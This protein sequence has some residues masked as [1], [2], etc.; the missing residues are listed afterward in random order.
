MSFQWSPQLVKIFVDCVLSEVRKGNTAEGGFK[1]QQWTCIVEAFNNHA[2]VAADKPVLQNK[3]MQMKKK[4]VI[5]K[6]L[7]SNS[8]FGWDDALQIPTAP[9][10]VWNSYLAVHKEAR[11]FQRKTFEYFDEFDEIYSDHIATGSHALSTQP[12]GVQMSRMS[13]ESVHVHAQEEEIER[14]AYSS[15]SSRNNSIH[16]T[17]TQIYDR[18]SSSLSSPP[19]SNLHSTGAIQVEKTTDALH[20]NVQV[21]SSSSSTFSRKRGRKGDIAEAILQAMKDR[22]A[23]PTMTANS[24]FGSI[25]ESRYVSAVQGANAI[26]KVWIKPRIVHNMG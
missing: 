2:G 13:A 11:E 23:P 14:N 16:S 19:I 4:F 3:L 10:S 9:E 18:A 17:P 7:K 21:L 1:K 8:G 22:R 12:Y 5:F 20:E 25:N 26:R 15:L 24:L 6:A